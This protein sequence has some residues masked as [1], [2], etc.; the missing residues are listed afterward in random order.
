MELANLHEEINYCCKFLIGKKDI[1]KNISNT[2]GKRINLEI[3]NDGIITNASPNFEY[4]ENYQKR[5]GYFWIIS[6]IDDSLENIL[7]SYKFRDSI[8]KEIKYSKS[9][10]DLDKTFASSD[11]AYEGKMLLG[12]ICAILRSII[13][14]KCK[15][16]FMQFFSETSQTIIKELDKI[17]SEEIN[18]EYILRYSLTAKQKQIMSLFGLGI[19]DVYNC[20]DNIN[21]TR[22]LTSKN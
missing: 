6:N 15:P 3:D 20:I 2:Y 13:V 12:F 7:K 1:N 21:F 18:G 4:L 10:C 16:F 22:K 17:K 19:K 9:L 8:E 14:L 5:Q 11:N